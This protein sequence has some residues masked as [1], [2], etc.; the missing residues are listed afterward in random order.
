MIF[1]VKKISDLGKYQG[2]ELNEKS[3][4]AYEKFTRMEHVGKI[5]FLVGPHLQSSNLKNM[6]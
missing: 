4:R 1:R 6:K 5:G 3:I 2:K